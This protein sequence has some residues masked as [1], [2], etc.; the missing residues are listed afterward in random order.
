MNKLPVIRPPHPG[1]LSN[2]KEPQASA[3]D[4][5]SQW[6]KDRMRGEWRAPKV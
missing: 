3:K 6:E 5:F 1:P 4:S 2:E